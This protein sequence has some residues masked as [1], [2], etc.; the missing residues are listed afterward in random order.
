M[1]ALKIWLGIAMIFFLGFM[2]GVFGTVVHIRAVIAKVEHSDP[3]ARKT[4]ILKRLVR[5]LDLTDE[6]A[7]QI[8]VV[9]EQGDKEMREIFGECRPRIRSALD[10]ALAEIR[11][12]LTVEQQQ[13]FEVM[14]RRLRQK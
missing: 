7:Q 6:Q 10:E 3:E 8:G 14:T 9:I 4:V 13:T 12:E 2:S 1:R 5:K 11:Q